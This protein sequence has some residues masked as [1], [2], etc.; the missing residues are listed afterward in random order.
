MHDGPDFLRSI[1]RQYVFFALSL[2]LSICL[3]GYLLYQIEIEDLVRSIKNL[4]MPT[5]ALYCF[6]S[7][8]GTLARAYRYFVLVH[9]RIID[10][11]SFVLVTLV[12]NLFVDLL[13]ARIGSLSYIY[14]TNRRFGFPFEIAASSFLVSF[15]FDFVVLFPLIFLAVFWIHFETIPLF[16]SM[17]VMACILG[18]IVIVVVLFYLAFILRFMLRRI[19]SVMHRCSLNKFSALKTGIDKLYSTAQDIDRIQKRKSDYGKIIFSSFLIRVFKYSSLYFLLHSVLNPFHFKIQDLNF[20]NVFLGILGAELSAVLPIQGLA[21]FGTWESAWSLTF[22][23]M[24]YFDSKIAIVSGF[25]V[26]LVTQVFEY[27]LGVLSLI[28]LYL[29]KRTKEK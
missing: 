21:G 9:P 5:L 20:F 23:M 15:L 17:F 27:F 13:P 12:R 29:P 8:L 16:S 3:V 22:K 6:L 4:Y 25:G 28:I 18:F 11:R 14:L 26:H 7:I 19:E 1:N 24:G 10:Y 2:L